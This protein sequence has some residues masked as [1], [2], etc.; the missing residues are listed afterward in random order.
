MVIQARLAVGWIT[1]DEATVQL[2]EVA[3]AEPEAEAE[4]DAEQGA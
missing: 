1:E 4:A 2:A 3:E